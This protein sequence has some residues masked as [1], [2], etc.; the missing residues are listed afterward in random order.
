MGY[1][2]YDQ[3]FLGGGWTYIWGGAY[4]GDVLVLYGKYI[5]FHKKYFKSFKLSTQ[6]SEFDLSNPKNKIVAYQQTQWGEHM[7][8]GWPLKWKL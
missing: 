8:Y 3:V 7:L 1:A 2:I 5:L 6:S 4:L